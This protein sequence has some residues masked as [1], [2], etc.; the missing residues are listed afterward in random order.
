MKLVKEKYS[1]PKNEEI[2]GS[3]VTESD[4]TNA[5]PIRKEPTP[6]VLKGPPPKKQLTQVDIRKTFAPTGCRPFQERR[7]IAHAHA[8]AKRIRC[9][10]N[11]TCKTNFCLNNISIKFHICFFLYQNIFDILTLDVIL[12]C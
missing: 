6:T 8:R 7:A 11:R 10:I 2:L 4:E 9:A 12:F 5:N 3:F 1:E